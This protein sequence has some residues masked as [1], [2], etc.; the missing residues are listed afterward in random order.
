MAGDLVRQAWRLMERQQR[1]G[2]EA[3][4]IRPHAGEEEEVSDQ[5]FLR[6]S[7]SPSVET[8]SASCLMGPVEGLSCTA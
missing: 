5:A 6:P 2:P 1:Q 8:L 7:G 4:E 3:S